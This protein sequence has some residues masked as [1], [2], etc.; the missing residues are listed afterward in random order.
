[1]T[2]R[3]FLS[4]IYIKPQP[5]LLSF[6]LTMSCFLSRIYIK[7]Q[8]RP[9]AYQCIFVVSYLVSTSNHN[10]EYFWSKVK[11]VVSYLVSTSN[12]NNGEMI[13]DE[14]LVVSYL[15]STSNHNC[16]NSFPLAL[17]VVSY[18]VSTSNHNTCPVL[19]DHFMLFLISYLH[20][21]T[22]PRQSTTTSTSCFL[23][24][25]YIKPQLPSR[26]VLLI[27]VVSYLVSTSNHNFCYIVFFV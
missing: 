19:V 8:L 3:C 11:S 7:P 1:M 15:V 6:I 16:S 12:H 24:R 17:S 26:D 27:D 10:L 14:D 4:R 23:S 5:C 25:I 9:A 2:H 18:L 20:Q 21:T 13:K 22:T